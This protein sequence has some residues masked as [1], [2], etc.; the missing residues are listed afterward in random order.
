MNIIE[1]PLEPRNCEC[2]GSTD[3]ESVWANESD[4]R[5]ATA[6]KLFHVRVIYRSADKIW[7]FIGN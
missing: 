6:T 7:F 4:A 3:L 1:V 5:W 2:C